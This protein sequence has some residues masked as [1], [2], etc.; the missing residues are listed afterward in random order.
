MIQPLMVGIGVLFVSLLCY[1][2]AM[3][4]MVQT[5]VW[6]IRTGCTGLSVWKN[7]AL[8]M[9]LSLVTTLVHLIEIALWALALLMC[10]ATSTFESAFYCS[11]QNYTALGYGDV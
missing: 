1:A 5:A 11:A 7:V 6:L 8:M 4:L 10:G 9:I 2:M 3:R